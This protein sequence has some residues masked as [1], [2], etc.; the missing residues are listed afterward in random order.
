[1]MSIASWEL[2]V[3]WTA[4]FEFCLINLSI[5]IP[6]W[7]IFGSLIAS[8]K[9][10]ST[11]NRKTVTKWNFTFEFRAKDRISSTRW[12][13]SLLNHVVITTVTW[14]L[15]PL[16]LQTSLTF[17]K[18]KQPAINSLWMRTH[19]CE[20]ECERYAIESTLVFRNHVMSS[21]MTEKKTQLHFI[22]RWIRWLI[23]CR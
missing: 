3:E 17:K 15:L 5:K 23:T 10:N 19:D 22:E 13:L 18:M 1:M 14:R 4:L 20:C 16:E 11:V 2:S 12:G 9:C 7:Y 8:R 21:R 6:I